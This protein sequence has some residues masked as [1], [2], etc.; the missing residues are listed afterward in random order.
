MKN[1]KE[2]LIDELSELRERLI[3]EI[4]LLEIKAK[5]GEETTYKLVDLLNV[6]NNMLKYVDYLLNDFKWED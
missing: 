6:Y 4:T 1:V 5:G 2:E 3:F